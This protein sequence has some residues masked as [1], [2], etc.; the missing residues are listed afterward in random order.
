M[1]SVAGQPFSRI[2]AANVELTSE[3]PQFVTVVADE[4]ASVTWS[5]RVAEDTIDFGPGTLAIDLDVTLSPR[6]WRTAQLIETDAA[7][8][9]HTPTVAVDLHGNVTAVWRQSD[10]TRYNIWSNMYR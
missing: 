1:Y 9:A 4:V 6:Q 3:N 7:G 10:G 2:P 5:F 8:D